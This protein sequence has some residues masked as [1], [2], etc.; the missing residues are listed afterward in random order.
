MCVTNLMA[1]TGPLRLS[2][3]LKLIFHFLRFL[4]WQAPVARGVFVSELQVVPLYREGGRQ[5]GGDRWRRRVMCLFV[6][7]VRCNHFMWGCWPTNRQNARAQ[8]WEIQIYHILIKYPYF[9]KSQM[10]QDSFI[11]QNQIC[12]VR[13]QGT[14]WLTEQIWTSERWTDTLVRPLPAAIH[15]VPQWG[16]LIWAER[17]DCF[18]RARP[19]E[20]TPSKGHMLRFWH[21]PPLNWPVGVTL[22]RAVKHC[23]VEAVWSYMLWC[24]LIT[25]H[26]FCGKCQHMM[27][28]KGQ[29][30]KGG[31]YIYSNIGWFS[32]ISHV[33]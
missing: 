2:P 11:F 1:L 29:T 7:F 21:F 24:V 4:T 12:S 33:W 19:W 26:V 15:T 20:N 5:L 14:T 16:W 13:Q 25:R 9:Q 18:W 17:R 32:C 8:G 28:R 30:E 27:L 10:T 31:L 6:C 22:P 23:M 3:H